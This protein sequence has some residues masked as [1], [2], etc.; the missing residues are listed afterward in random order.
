MIQIEEEIKKAGEGSVGQT[1]LSR[2]TLAEK[3]KVAFPQDKKLQ[4]SLFIKLDLAK[5]NTNKIKNLM[6]KKIIELQLLKQ[7]SLKQVFDNLL[8]EG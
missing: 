4:E 5:Q 8:I 2:T 1:E 6:E 7:A 3:F